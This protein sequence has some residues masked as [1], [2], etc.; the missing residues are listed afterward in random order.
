MVEGE[1]YPFTITSMKRKE[2]RRR[3]M[4]NIKLV[5]NRAVGIIIRLN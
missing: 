1:T 4:L 2:K 5:N 3:D